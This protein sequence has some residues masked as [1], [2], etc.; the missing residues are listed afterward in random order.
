MKPS[1]PQFEVHANGRRQFTGPHDEA[2]SAAD[3][4]AA[5]GASVWLTRKGTVDRLNRSR[6]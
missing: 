3:T 6:A 1:I 2:S 5:S 4:L